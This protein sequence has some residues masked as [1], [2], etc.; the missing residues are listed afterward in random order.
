MRI[1]PPPQFP[2]YASATAQYASTANPDQAIRHRRR[3]RARSAVNMAVWGRGPSAGMA[4]HIRYPQLPRRSKP[5]T[6]RTDY[7]KLPNGYLYRISVPS[8]Y[9]ISNGNSLD[10]QIFDTDSYN[11]TAPGSGDCSFATTV[12]Q[13]VI[14]REPKPG[15]RQPIYCRID[16]LRQRA[17]TGVDQA[18]THASRSGISRQRP[19]VSSTQV[20]RGYQYLT[21]TPMAVSPGGGRI[22]RCQYTTCNG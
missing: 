19:R 13:I 4:T 22:G 7:G 20:D 10:I 16:E 5:A 2:L 1:V 8:T 11:P 12:L 9:V 15:V 17:D 6:R 18:T 3:L 21:Y 14:L